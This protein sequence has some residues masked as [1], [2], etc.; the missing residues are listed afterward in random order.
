MARKKK[1]VKKTGNAIP[2]GYT[3]ISSQSRSWPNEETSIGDAIEGTVI[4]Y[5]YEVK[6]SNGT[7]DLLRVETK[8]GAV[9][10][11]WKSAVLSPL[12][13]E[14][15]TDYEL[16]IRFDGHGPKKRGKNPVKLFTIAYKE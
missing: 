8:D 9:Y 14:D 15:Y 6:T 11:V 1:V 16:Y 4:D 13:D 3:A 7:T 12:F 5:Q 10:T 2:K